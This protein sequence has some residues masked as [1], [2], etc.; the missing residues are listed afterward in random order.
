M[1]LV[2]L[3]WQILVVKFSVIVFYLNGVNKVKAFIEFSTF[4][5]LSL[6]L[7]VFE[8]DSLSVLSLVFYLLNYWSLVKVAMDRLH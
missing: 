4:K 5:V 3:S 7:Q 6:K 1:H 2:C 8:H